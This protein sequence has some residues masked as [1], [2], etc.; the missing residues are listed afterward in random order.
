MVSYKSVC[1]KFCDFNLF[2]RLSVEAELTELLD[3]GNRKDKMEMEGTEDIY[4]SVDELQLQ[5]HSHKPPIVMDH[6]PV[7]D[8]RDVL[9]E[10]SLNK[11][12][13]I[14]YYI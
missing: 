5:L 9:Q 3:I 6:Q 4:C 14:H 10:I 1:F 8:R 13:L 2:F 11:V 7:S 12:L